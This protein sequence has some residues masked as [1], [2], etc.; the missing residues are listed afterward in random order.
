MS[1]YSLFLDEELLAPRSAGEVSLGAKGQG[2]D[3]VVF[4]ILLLHHVENHSDPGKARPVVARVF[5]C[6]P[7]REDTGLLQRDVAHGL[8]S[9][10][11]IEFVF[12]FLFF[13]CHGRPR[14]Q[15]L[16]CQP[17]YK[18]KGARSK[19]RLAGESV[20][21][22]IGTGARSPSARANRS[23]WPRD[24]QAGGRPASWAGW[25]VPSD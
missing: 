8:A 19:G 22:G 14:F 13:F 11:E 1:D 23:L 21:A 6:R 2:D 24:W 25:K 9:Q 5:P 4:P 17:H 16:G 18:H 12:L 7:H 15:R 3:V 10:V 20:D